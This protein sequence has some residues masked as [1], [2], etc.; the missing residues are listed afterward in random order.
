MIRRKEEIG[1]RRIENAQGGKGIVTFY[2][3]LLPEEA[4]GHGKVFSTL[5]VPPGCS[6]G[7]HVHEGTFEAYLVLSGE[8]TVND[9]GTVAVLKAGDM[10][11][12]DEGQGHSTT[13][14]GSED[15]VLMALIMNA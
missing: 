6:I 8:A 14:N 11:Y 15:L 7:Y 3:W 10:N 4:K 13:N 9:N 5:V 1:K 12:C 2:D